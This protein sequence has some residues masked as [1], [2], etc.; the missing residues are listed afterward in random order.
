LAGEAAAD[1]IDRRE[2]R[3][4]DLAHVLE[5]LRLGE[6]PREDRPAVGVE[7]D[8]PGDP[9]A[10]A[11]ETEVEATDSREEA[12]DIHAPPLAVEEAGDASLSGVVKTSIQLAG[13]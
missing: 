13:S 5:A 6:V 9:H 4:P 2:V 1:E 11:F 10:G 8:L 12:A 3:R 7:L